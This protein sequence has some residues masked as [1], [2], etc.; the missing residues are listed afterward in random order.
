MPPTSGVYENA[1]WE[2]ID[3]HSLV[4]PLIRQGR[5][6]FQ[7]SP[8][9]YSEEQNPSNTTEALNV[10]SDFNCFSGIVVALPLSLLAWAAI[11]TFLYL[12]FHFFQ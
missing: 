6:N 3:N 1:D 9:V 5:T 4:G 2:F 10:C 8:V 7:D 12:L 11:L